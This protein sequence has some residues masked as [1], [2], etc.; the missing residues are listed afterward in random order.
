MCYN[1]Y[2]NQLAVGVG[3]TLT[4]RCWRTGGLFLFYLSQKSSLASGI[5]S[6]GS[7]LFGSGNVDFK[8]SMCS[9]KSG[10]MGAHIGSRIKSMPSLRANLAAG[11]KSLSP[12]ISILCVLP[13]VY[14]LERQCQYRFAYLR[15]FVW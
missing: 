13:V 15:L 7:F 1:I 8:P 11:T 14:R 9:N 12:A 3:V 6:L 5:A 2:S 4:V 10:F